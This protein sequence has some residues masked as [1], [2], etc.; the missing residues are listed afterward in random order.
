MIRKNI[1]ILIACEESQAE[2][3]AFR[4][5][6]FNAWSC[7]IQPCKKGTPAAWHIIG[8]V[9]PFLQGK[10]TF[11]TQDGKRHSLRQWH[12]ILAHPPCTY[13]CKVSSVQLWKNHVLDESRLEKMK[14]AV[15][16]FKMCLDARADFVAVENPLPMKRA[17]LPKP[18]CYAC[19]SWFGAKYTK[20]TLYWTKNLPPLLPKIINPNAKSFVRSSKGKYRSRTLPQLAQAIAEQWGEYI[21][22]VLNEKKN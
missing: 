18:S 5:L 7:D 9:T 10:T 8:N 14:E 11:K 3:K 21:Y 2:T 17:S 20:K 19:P 1:N 16:F 12:F 6:G 22:R 4:S 15:K 13:I